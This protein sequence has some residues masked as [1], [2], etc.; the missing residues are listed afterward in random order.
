MDTRIAT[1]T[2]QSAVLRPG[3]LPADK[4]YAM[5]CWL[6]SDLSKFW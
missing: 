4:H 6:N 5:P 1:E 2:K 3:Q